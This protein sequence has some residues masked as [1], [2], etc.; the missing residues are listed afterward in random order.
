MA[1][2]RVGSYGRL[3]GKVQQTRVNLGTQLMEAIDQCQEQKKGKQF[4]VCNVVG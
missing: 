2:L 1:I 4:I 3:V